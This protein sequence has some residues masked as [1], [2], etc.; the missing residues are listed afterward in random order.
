MVTI[1]TKNSSTSCRSARQ[2]L[3]NHDID[4]EEHKI[5]I[6]TNDVFCFMTD[7][8]TDLIEDCSFSIKT[9]QDLH[10]QISDLINHNPCKDD[11]TAIL[12]KVK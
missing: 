1:I 3:D 8:I 7:G 12:I 10:Q 2:W 9:L 4:Y 6:S 5:P 11:T